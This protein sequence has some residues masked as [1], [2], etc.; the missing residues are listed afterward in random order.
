L[1]ETVHRRGLRRR[2]AVPQ[3]GQAVIGSVGDL[4]GVEQQSS[5]ATVTSSGCGSLT[6][7]IFTLLS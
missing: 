5:I 7:R 2:S 6:Y 1:G 3:H 4:A